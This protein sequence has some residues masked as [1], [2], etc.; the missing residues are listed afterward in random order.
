MKRHREE[1]HVQKTYASV[2][3][4]PHSG[5]PPSATTALHSIVV[6]SKD[7]QDT[8]DKVI[9]RIRKVVNAKEEGIKIDKIRKAKERKVIIGF[10]DKEEL[11][12][13]K[14]KIVKA[15]HELTV[16][17]MTNKDP[18]VVMKDVLNFH[19]DDEVISALKLQN[20]NI[21]GKIDTNK[22]RMEVKYRK[23]TR[24]PLMS[25]FVLK[26][27]PEVWQTLTEAGA[28][29]IDIQRIR[30]ADQS[31]IVQCTKCLGFGHGRKFCKA[32]LD[33]CSHCGGPH[34]RTECAD[35]L[36]AVAP[37]CCNCVK[38]KIDDANHNAFSQECPVWRRWD[39]IARS[40]VNYC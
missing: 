25:H 33:V 21:L 9:E 32:T 7:D 28:V 16:E 37:T 3:A 26:V 24:N 27:S 14:Q 39:T 38:A 6:T 12:K 23:R 10:T 20:K 34:M 29:H 11:R 8:G 2:A 5:K 18:L 31:P 40:S 15:G 36:A 30:V 1:A 35:W 17:E 19:T 22:M 13:V 4:G